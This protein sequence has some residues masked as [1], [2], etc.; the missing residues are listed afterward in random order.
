MPSTG[1]R[2]AGSVCRPKKTKKTAANRSRSGV[3]QLPGGVGERPGQRDADQERA[4][5]GRDLQLL[6]DAGDEHGQAERP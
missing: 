5:R 1:G 2:S 6:G 4:D 3:E